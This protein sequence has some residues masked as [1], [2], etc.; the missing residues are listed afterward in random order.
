MKFLQHILI[1]IF[2]LASNYSSAQ[3]VSDF[4]VNDDT[5]GNVFKHRANVSTNKNG[6]SAI[7]WEEYNLQ[8]IFAQIYENNFTKINNNFKI[9]T[10]IDSCNSPNVI[11]TNKDKI[12]IVW[13]KTGRFYG[14]L[15]FRLFNKYGLPLTSAIQLNDTLNGYFVLPNIG[16]DSSGRFIVSWSYG[17]NDIYYQIIDSTG[18]KIGNNVKVNEDNTGWGQ[19]DITVKK[20]G[21]FII[22][23][24]DS[25]Y[26]GDNIYMQMYNKNGNPIGVNQKV[27]DTIA[28]LFYSFS[29]PK[30]ANDSS[31]NFTIAFNT[32]TY[33][34][35]MT[36]VRYQRYNKDGVKIGYNKQFGGSF[37]TPLSSF[38]SDEIGNLIFQLNFDYAMNLRID[39]F[40]N[41]IGSYF[42]ISNEYVESGKTGEDIKLH[43]NRIINVW[44]DIRAG[45]QP[46]IY[47]NVRSYINP[48][49]T[50]GI[51]KIWSE[52]PNKFKLFQNYPN[53][54][55]QCT[56]IKFQCTIKS[57]VILKIYDILGKE[58]ATLVN[59]K[60]EPGTYEVSFEGNN[61][62]TGVYFY[63]IQSGDFVQ[64]KKML[65][66]K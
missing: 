27:N 42:L 58:I 43:N 32:Y 24:R 40:D 23:W 53:P 56:I 49:S 7:V 30:I 20:D 35:N 64:V 60:Q 44:R 11:V 66:I 5:A 52:I 1:L 12:G 38:D 8:N 6:L 55:N 13:S 41:P 62:S 18:N 15:F 28:A 63:R 22:V 21:S 29:T 36:Y 50:V 61:F 37:T 48:D 33:N 51:I 46:Q 25:R 9:N 4:K 34:D 3:L 14:R 57:D 10:G 26:P 45:Q 59:G 31:G 17:Y 39:R 54:F 47:A 65:M 2:L 19:Q 16:C